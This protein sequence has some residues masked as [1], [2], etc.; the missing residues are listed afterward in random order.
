MPTGMPCGVHRTQSPQ[1]LPG[2]EPGIAR[3]AGQYGGMSGTD[4][5]GPDGSVRLRCYLPPADTIWFSAGCDGL[6]GCG[7]SAPIG[8]RGA[9]RLMVSGDMRGAGR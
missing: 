9:I 7:H 8:I 6:A 5:I 2:P 1:H 3:A 4:D